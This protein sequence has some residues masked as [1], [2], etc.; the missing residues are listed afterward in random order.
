MANNFQIALTNVPFDNEFN[1]VLRF[2]SR[3]EQEAYF[4]VNTLF[5]NAPKVNFNVGAFEVTNVFVNYPA[6]TDLTSLMNNNY[7]IVKDTTN[8]IYYYYFVEMCLQ[9]SGT[10]LA[11]NLKMDIFQTYYID[12]NFTDC[13]IRRAHLNRWYNTSSDPVA[14][15]GSVNSQLFETEKLTPLPKRLT[16]RTKI[17]LNI[18]STANSQLNEWLHK[19]AYWQYVFVSASPIDLKFDSGNIVAKLDPL[20]YFNKTTDLSGID[21]GCAVLCFPIM[22]Q[23]YSL[24]GLKFD[25]GQGNTLTI[26]EFGLRNFK[27][28]NTNTSY[29]YA[30][31]LSIMPPFEYRQYNANEYSINAD[32][33][34]IHATPYTNNWSFGNNIDIYKIMGS[35]GLIHLKTQILTELKSSYTI[36]DDFSFTKSTIKG[37]K[38]P[39]FNPKLL[40]ENYKELKLT[41]GSDGFN[42]DIQK[43]NSK[44]LTILYSEPITPDVTRSYMRVNT[45]GI[46]IADC[47]KNFTGLVSAQDNSLP[48]Q[49]DQLSVWLANNKNYYMQATVGAIGQMAN[50]LIGGI[51]GGASKGV[52]GSIA[53]ATTG[54][55]TTGLNVLTKFANLDLTID[56]MRSAPGILKNSN[57]NAPLNANITELGLF[58]EEYSALNNELSIINDKMFMFGFTYNKIGN[59]KNFDNIRHYFNYIEADVEMI[60]S[61]KNLSNIIK[62]RFIEAFNRGVRFWNAEEN[63]FDGT[64]SYANENYERSL[65]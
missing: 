50:G 64:F 37:I 22:K 45:T 2:G 26:D 56:N 4:D 39:K 57:G 44:N 11:L 38:N 42:Y 43:L 9:D 40:N 8:K 10:Q 53:G 3:L 18:D 6:G 28:F 46:Y 23:N 34:T 21:A 24:G 27:A 36:T 63:V 35:F 16:K 33:I 32:T 17:E 54:L 29:F 41:S 5:L 14:F 1:N 19:V 49:N 20:T 60:T 51:V 62:S 31:K 47:A 48:I 61:T 59:I 25:D 65:E 55:A 52:A 12:V 15:D 7:A 30:T 58:I 13:N